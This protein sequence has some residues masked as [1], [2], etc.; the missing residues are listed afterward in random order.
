MDPELKAFLGFVGILAAWVAIPVVPAWLTF[1]IT[2]AQELGLA[3][4][5]QGLTLRAGGAF[6]AYLVVFMLVTLF[7]WNVGT[8]VVGQMM[9]DAAW[10]VSAGVTLVSAEGG[11][12]RTAPDMSLATVQMSPDPNVI[13]PERV[14]LPLPLRD[15]AKGSFYVRVP[16]WGGA[17]ILLHDARGYDVNPFTREITLKDKLVFREQ[18]S[19]GASIGPPLA[20]GKD[21]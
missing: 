9:K 5:F 3:G 7:V 2:P 6:A 12:A 4:P 20:P 10:T 19:R 18:T 13:T 16:G 21:E 15:Y 11:P 14:T 8:G 1:R 17:R